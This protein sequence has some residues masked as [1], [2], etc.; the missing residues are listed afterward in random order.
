M[1]LNRIAYIHTGRDSKFYI[2]IRDKMLSMSDRVWDIIIK[3]YTNGDEVDLP[4][5]IASIRARKIL[6]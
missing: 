4:K 3:K 1:V 5:V 6:K 2:L